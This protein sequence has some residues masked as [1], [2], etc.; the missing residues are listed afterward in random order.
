MNINGKLNGSLDKWLLIPLIGTII[1]LII[2]LI[3]FS[4]ILYQKSVSVINLG[5]MTMHT[6]F[7]FFLSKYG[8]HNIVPVWY[9][10]FKLF[11][12]Y[13]PGWYFFTLPIYR[14][15]SDINLTIFIS[16]IVM[17]LLGLIASLLLGKYKNLSITKSLVFFALF[18]INPIAIDYIFSNGRF[19]EFF[20]WIIFVFLLAILGF[21]EH[22]NSNKY[23]LILLTITLS[24]LILSHPYVS[25]L[26]LFLTFLILL[27]VRKQNKYNIILA[28]ILS[29]ILTSFW[30]IPFLQG[31]LSFPAEVIQITDYQK[32]QLLDLKNSIISFNTATLLSWFFIFYA[33]WTSSKKTKKEKM[34]Y[35]PLLFLSLLILFRI[36]PFLPLLDQI[37]PNSYNLFYISIS[38]LTLFKIRKF[39]PKIKKIFIISLILL[40][41]LSFIVVF[42]IRP[43]ESLEF[44]EQ[45]MKIINLIPQIEGR[46]LFIDS[47]LPHVAP[48]NIISIATQNYNL[49]TPTGI[50]Y[51]ATPKR[52]YE[53]VAKINKSLNEKNCKELSENLNL[54]DVKTIISQKQTNCEI[55]KQCSLKQIY[56]DKDVCFYLR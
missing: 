13:P 47:S 10:G 14:F 52:T 11:Q 12:L 5:D 33:Y 37:P 28:V 7:L 36:T 38:L 43:Q 4:E 56:L 8:F 23:S 24:I 55:L 9:D 19:P 1:I 2:K 42:H 25:V 41:I 15:F 31:F 21:Y 45:E 18:L 6:S 22:N 26:G 48:K 50:Y 35:Y 29:I 40:P 20:A 39:S 46:Y 27:I 3:E 30:W 32:G 34:F 16:Y 49:P 51:P 53:L 44:T 54:L 17:L